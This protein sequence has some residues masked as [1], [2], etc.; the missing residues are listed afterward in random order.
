MSKSKSVSDCNKEGENFR[1]SIVGEKFAENTYMECQI[2]RIGG[3]GMP[4]FLKFLLG[5][6]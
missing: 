1:G 2:N 3:W 4:K 5:K 6:L